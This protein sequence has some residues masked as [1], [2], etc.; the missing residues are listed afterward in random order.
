MIFLLG[1]V[2]LSAWAVAG[3][4]AYFAGSTLAS[5]VD[6]TPVGG[7]VGIGCAF[8]LLVWSTG[9]VLGLILAHSQVNAG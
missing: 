2:W 8:A 7:A 5:R 1:I 9:L 3:I 4:V 6:G